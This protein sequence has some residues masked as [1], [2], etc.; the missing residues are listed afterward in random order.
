MDFNDILE[1][2]RTDS[3]SKREMGTRFEVL[4]KAYLRTDPLYT[5][6]LR[7]IWLWS[8]FSTIERLGEVDTGIDLV[9]KTRFNE[10]W[11]IQC[12]W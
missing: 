11:A 3:L 1:K 12:K 10:Y 9:A 5:S 8:D 7:D 2:Y 4:M 6:E